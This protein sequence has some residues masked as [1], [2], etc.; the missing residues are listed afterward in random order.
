MR[1]FLS[2]VE[3]F[4]LATFAASLSAAEPALREALQDE[5]AVG[6]EGWIYNDVARGFAEAKRTGKPLFVTFRCVP[7]KD[8]EG[9]DAEVAKGSEIIQQLAAEHFVPVRQV[10]MKGVDLSQFQFDHDL[11]WAA[12]FLN[13]DGTVYARFGT[14]SAAGADAYNSIEGLSAT[15]R[16]VLELHKN[17]P[18]NKAELE[19][20]RGD[21]KPYETALDMRGLEN[22][23]KLA[24]AT[25]RNNCIHC[26][27]IHDA[28]Q[29][30]AYDAG[31][32]DEDLLWRYP[33]PENIG[34]VI[35]PQSGV[36]VMKVLPDSAAQAA[37]LS[38][39]DEITH[40]NGQAITSIAD[41]QWV[42]HGLSNDD[43]TVT[44]RT[45]D[46][47][48]ELS[49]PAGWKRTDISWRGSFWSLRPKLPIWMEPAD[50]VQRKAAGVSEDE[51][52]LLVK[53]INRGRAGG[54]AAYEAGL[55]EGDLVVALDGQPL[56]FEKSPSFVMHVKLN[57]DVDDALPL[58]VIGKN[59][60]RRQVTVQLVE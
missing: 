21:D 32:F 2:F 56:R 50:E 6:A 49:L 17:Y 59:G 53:W 43:A 54:K 44:V 47:E 39:G 37:G 25:A 45:R 36:R 20:K 8:C 19:G 22:K 57:Y 4:A 34:L 3:V 31:T 28:E 52:P 27:M 14:Q 9:F 55:R 1:R 29:N 30:A 58:T 5:H 33:L 51:I 18:A 24:G 12:M 16:R 23:E 26:H 41:I 60:E 13:A 38:K 10:E 46:G 48:Q 11:N 7:C 35:N 40:V 42:L 15:M